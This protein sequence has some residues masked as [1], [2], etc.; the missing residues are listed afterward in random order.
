MFTLTTI[1]NARRQNLD[2]T[3]DAIGSQ[4][5][6]T[7]ITASWEG[8]FNSAKEDRST[9]ANLQDQGNKINEHGNRP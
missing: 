7:V 9:G 3:T 2:G 6:L 5:Y 8:G 1:A 4:L